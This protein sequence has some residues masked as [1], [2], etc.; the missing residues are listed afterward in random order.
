M[1][2]HTAGGLKLETGAGLPLSNLAMGHAPAHVFRLRA[3][4]L[5]LHAGLK[6]RKGISLSCLA[7]Y[8]TRAHGPMRAVRLCLHA[9]LDV[10]R[11][12]LQQMPAYQAWLAQPKAF[13]PEMQFRGRD[14][15]VINHDSR[16][17]SLCYSTPPD[18]D[19]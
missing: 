5:C 4:R 7:V 8:D 13:A 18:I 15:V 17:A 9:G 16:R 10:E 19:F 14:E 11:S 2:R 12:E 3:V 1:Q 6:K